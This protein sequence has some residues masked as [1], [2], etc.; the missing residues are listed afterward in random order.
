VLY[1]PNR[2]TVE[3]LRT[4]IQRCGLHRISHI[5]LANPCQEPSTEEPTNPPTE[6]VF[7]R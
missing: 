5:V 4:L 7:V 6:A 2:V 1:D 3:E